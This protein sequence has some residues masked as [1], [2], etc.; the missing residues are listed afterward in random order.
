M[1]RMWR[2]KKS[3]TTD[4]RGTIIEAELFQMRENFANVTISHTF[5]NQ[6]PKR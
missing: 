2:G 4:F 6:I 5:S 3:I 1:L